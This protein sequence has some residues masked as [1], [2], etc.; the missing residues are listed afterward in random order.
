[1]SIQVEK[2]HGI[3]MFTEKNKNENL[4]GEWLWDD[5]MERFN[6]LLQNHSNYRPVETWRVQLLDTIPP[7]PTNEKHIQFLYSSLSRDN[8]NDNWLLY[9]RGNW[10]CSYYDRKNIFIYD[11]LNNKRLEKDHEQF[12]KKLFP[13]YDFIQNPV[14]FPTVQQQP[15]GSDCGVFAIAFAVSLLFNIKPEKVQ[16]NHSLMRPH[17]IKMFEINIIDHFP[18]F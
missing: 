12:L 8:A 3:S 1:M 7:I 15:N 14:Q 16:Y 4:R 17:L 2:K 10:V 9:G 11:F 18:K 5:D 6:C 13:A